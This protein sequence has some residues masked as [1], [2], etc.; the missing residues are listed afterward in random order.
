VDGSRQS[1][2]FASSGQLSLSDDTTG[3][4]RISQ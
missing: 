3:L 2:G 1:P 4:P